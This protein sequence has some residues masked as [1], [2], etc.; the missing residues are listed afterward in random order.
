MAESAP[1]RAFS[2]S[3][4]A[5]FAREVSPQVEAALREAEANGRAGQFE[6]AY[7]RLATVAAGLGHDSDDDR[8]AIGEL[9]ILMWV[10][11]GRAAEIRPIVDGLL[12]NA[13]TSR[14]RAVLLF[15]RARAETGRAAID[16]FKEALAEFADAGDGRG[17]AITLSELGYL[18][19]DGMSGEA[20]LRFSREG[21]ARAE[22]LGDPWALAY[23]LCRSAATEA[24]LD[25]PGAM[26][27]AE[28]AARALPLDSDPLTF[29]VV[30]MSQNNWAAIAW[31]HG[32]YPLASAIAK[33][34]RVLSRGATWERY[35]DGLD[36]LGSWR[37]GHLS[38]V[39]A[40]LAAIPRERQDGSL[41]LA[42]A[43]L[44]LEQG[45][46]LSTG[47]IDKAVELLSLD[48]Q[49]MLQAR[50]LQAQIRAARHEPDP[51]RDLG[52]VFTQVSHLELRFGWED[53]M[54]AFARLRPKAARHALDR[55]QHLW[56]SYPRATHM[57][58]FVNG[59]VP[60]GAGFTSLCE[61]AEGFSDLGERITAGQ[62]MHAAAR[63]APSIAEGNRLRRQA[64]ELF[65]ACGA[66][67][68][69]AAVVRE[70]RT[71]RGEGHV[72]IPESQRHVP[73]AGLTEREREVA[74]LAARG[75]TAQEISLELGISVG[76]ARNHLLKVR[77]K[78]G[79]VAK[80]RLVELLASSRED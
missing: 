26:A 22:Q 50:A 11:S 5:S 62:A 80:R 51:T 74:Q 42:Q 43:A 45:R 77:E 8:I 37:T 6:N 7:A 57:H 66:D 9:A 54:L 61:A 20:R 19:H 23:C 70:R 2:G 44:E 79:G 46:R 24:F 75:L 28:S 17:A 68:S 14:A 60:D 64:I 59:L 21:L 40:I 78:F 36:A 4:V 69:L 30:C 13:T 10:W 53:A 3:V 16:G 65:Q 33:E 52:A 15:H 12:S 47:T 27:R 67:R 58:R 49:I 71:H 39:S 18:L 25:T 76:T 63:L 34:G 41:L 48:L 55:L 38:E 56:P 32:D 29:E 72:P 31:Q 35:Y 73:H 1:R